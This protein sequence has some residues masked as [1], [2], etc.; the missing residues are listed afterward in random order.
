MVTLAARR[1]IAA[2][3][4]PAP[5][6]MIHTPQFSLNLK[7]NIA[8]PIPSKMQRIRTTIKTV[9]VVLSYGKNS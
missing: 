1:I 8:A 7:A 4:T 6:P 3:K 5:I 2:R 9:R